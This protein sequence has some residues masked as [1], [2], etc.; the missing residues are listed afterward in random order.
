MEIAAA[1]MMLALTT[2]IVG[3]WRAGKDPSMLWASSLIST[4]MLLN[5]DYLYTLT[6]T[7]LGGHNWVDLAANLLLLLGVYFLVRGIIRGA[8]SL[9]YSKQTFES[10]ARCA[11]QAV[12]L[13]VVLLFVCFMEVPLTSAQFMKDYGDQGGVALYSAVQYAF[14]G[15]SMA[16]AAVTCFRFRKFW[17]ATLYRRAFTA[18]GSG[19]YLALLLSLIIIL[20]DWTHYL[21]HLDAVA[22]LSLVYPWLHSASFFFLCTGLSFPPAV[23]RLREW[24]E[25]VDTQKVTDLLYPTWKLAVQGNALITLNTQVLTRKRGWELARLHRMVIEVHD[26][27]AMDTSMR[28]RLGP[29]RLKSLTQAAEYLDKLSKRPR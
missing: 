4:S 14:I 7:S 11:M 8:S 16:S 5:I 28:A 15:A 27:M 20:M 1:G 23:R 3:S 21:G 6:D 18:V 29:E 22:M 10:W 25:P 19:C 24:L 13:C 2:I 17:T 26:C 9:E 12:C